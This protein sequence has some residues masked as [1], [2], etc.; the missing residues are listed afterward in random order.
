MLLGYSER[1]AKYDIFGH[2]IVQFLEIVISKVPTFSF[3]IR[4]AAD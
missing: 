4:R 2:G 3:S 1:L